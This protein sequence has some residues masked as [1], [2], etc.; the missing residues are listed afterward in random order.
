MTAVAAFVVAWLVCWTVLAV[1]ERL[2]QVEAHLRADRTYD[3]QE[4]P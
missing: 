3:E 2:D 1:G 4:T